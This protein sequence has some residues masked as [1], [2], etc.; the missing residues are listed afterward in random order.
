[1]KKWQK[2]GALVAL[3]G[4]LGGCALFGL[5]AP[6]PPSQVEASD[7]TYEDEVQVT[8]APSSG[9]RRYE[10]FRAAAEAGPY[11]RIG[12]TTDTSFADVDVAPN[13]YY[14]Y[15]V[16]AC[17][18]GGCSDLSSPDSGYILGPG[19]PGIPQHIQASDGTFSDKV[20]VSWTASL[21]ADYY[22]VY[23]SPTSAGGFFFRGRTSATSFDD[24]DV[25]P[26][27]T[28]WYKVKACNSWGCSDFSQLDSGYV[29]TQGAPTTAPTVE[30][31]DGTYSDRVRVTW[32][33]ISGAARYEI[34]RAESEAGPYTSLRADLTTTSYDDTTVVVGR[35]YW[36][37][38]RACNSAGCGPESDPDSGYAAS[39]GGGG[40]GGTPGLPAQPWN[41]AASD[42]AY[43]DKIRVTW[44]SVSGARRYEIWKSD[45][46]TGTFTQLG[47]TTGTSYDDT[48][49]TLCQEWWYKVRACNEAG[50]GP[51]SVADSG[52]RG[53]T[54][55][56]VNTSKVK[57]TVTP[58][59]KTTAD[60]KLEWEAVK[61]ATLFDVRYEIWRRGTAGASAL[62][63]KTDA[64]GDLTWTDEDCPLGTTF[65]YKIR[66]VST[67]RNLIQPPG[68]ECPACGLC[69]LPGPFSGEVTATIACNPTP[70]GGTINAEWSN[71]ESKVYVSWTAVT[72]ATGY[73]VYRATSPTGSYTKVGEV[74]SSPPEQ[75]ATTYTDTGL[76]AG[77]YYY[78]V[79]TCV[80][81]GCGG[82][83][84]ASNAVTIP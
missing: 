37:Q 44:S 7:G 61:D 76:P 63:H 5:V 21:G 70:P 41:V 12:E 9:A 48:S 18:S 67:Y 2:I 14:W 10:V 19:A 77:T 31:S 30:A 33:A 29:V 45:T 66:A 52:Y 60:V 81:C 38:V 79:K 65:Y 83:S 28:Y 43:A 57:V 4:L 75:P 46:D 3:L 13:T 17:N 42:G 34:E 73:E 27:R 80:A 16:K 59:S 82:L 15:G 49:T 36:Y 62:V 58:V 47:E 25:V 40:G 11:E 23:R 20:R 50:C 55:E 69:I 54:L 32:N 72:G 1:M 84:A 64:A 78:K 74:L 35:T 24:T 8:W 6:S 39:G 68:T 22:D 71:S 51:D 26:G 53:G 56:Q